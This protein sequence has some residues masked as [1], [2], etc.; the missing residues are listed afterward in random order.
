MSQWPAWITA[1]LSLTQNHIIKTTKPEHTQ[2]LKF[3]YH[4]LITSRKQ[5]QMIFNQN[6]FLQSHHEKGYGVVFDESNGSTEY[7]I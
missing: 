4:T 1:M 3:V 7:L 5:Q 6:L 2:L